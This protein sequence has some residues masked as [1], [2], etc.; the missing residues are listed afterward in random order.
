VQGGE[1][2]SAICLE[3]VTQMHIIG[4]HRV[5]QSITVKGLPFLVETLQFSLAVDHFDTA[6]EMTTTEESS[7]SNATEGFYGTPRYHI[8]QR[9]LPS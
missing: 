7:H 2:G 3:I 9:R 5:V 8:Q 4:M 1:G 6:A